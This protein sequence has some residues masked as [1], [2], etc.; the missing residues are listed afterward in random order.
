MVQ[1]YT[2]MTPIC[3]RL[4]N[5]TLQTR[6]QRHPSRDRSQVSYGRVLT[7][8]PQ[9]FT[10]PC[11]RSLRSSVVSVY[12]LRDPFLL[13][14]FDL[15]LTSSPNLTSC[16]VLASTSRDPPFR[17]NQYQSGC[18][19][20][21]RLPCAGPTLPLQWFLTLLLNPVTSRLPAAR[22]ASLRRARAFPTTLCLQC[23]IYHFSITLANRHNLSTS[24]LPSSHLTPSSPPLLSQ[25][26]PQRRTQIPSTRPHAA[27]YS[28]C[29]PHRPP[30][31]SPTPC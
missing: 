9:P 7:N 18:A 17:Y 19:S 4:R 26:P 15:F 20:R 12:N 30:A 22:A 25:A 3:G 6:R 23:S 29:P 5:P 13:N 31:T 8:Q 2:C 27:F 1:K 28:H 21:H 16:C 11:L 10:V 14:T 24:P